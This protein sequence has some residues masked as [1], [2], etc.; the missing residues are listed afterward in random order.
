MW[1]NPI[2]HHYAVITNYNRQPAQTIL[3][4]RQMLSKVDSLNT[5]PSVLSQARFFCI[6]MFLHIEELPY[7][8]SQII[9]ASNPMAIPTELF[10]LS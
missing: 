5:F 10:D 9:V 6:F 1:P 4:P 3:A 8:L 7:R 2:H